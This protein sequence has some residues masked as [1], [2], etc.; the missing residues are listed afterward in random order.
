MMES[1]IESMDTKKLIGMCMEMSFANNKTPQ[2]FREFMPNRGKI[3][4][5]VTTDHISMQKYQSS[6]LQQMF[7]PDRPFVKWA[8]V[9]VSDFTEKPGGMKT[10]TLEGGLYA[11][12][13]HKGPASTFPQS[14]QYIFS[15]WLPQSS[16]ELDN[17]EHFEVLPQGYSPVDPNATEENWI[18]I[19][20]S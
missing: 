17:R 10:Y 5:R 20:E 7:A 1:R 18:P 12:F 14:M 19:R 6:D 11:V 13:S 4:N 2:L 3:L 16:Y 15:S 8:V 9:E